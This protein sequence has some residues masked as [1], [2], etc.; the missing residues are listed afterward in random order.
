M[1]GNIGRVNEWQSFFQL[2]VP[3][4]IVGFFQSHQI[5]R[6]VA[7]AMDVTRK[8]NVDPL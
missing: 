4:A 6:T 2:S 7:S 1:K 3:P 8:K 5:N